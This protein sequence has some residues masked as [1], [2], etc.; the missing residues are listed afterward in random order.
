MVSLL[1]RQLWL[2]GG[3]ICCFGFGL[4][5]LFPVDVTLY[6]HFKLYSCSGDVVVET[7]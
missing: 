1:R 2:R 5:A 7:E 3:R 4:V 6:L